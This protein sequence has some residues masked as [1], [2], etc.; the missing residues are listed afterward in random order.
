M[1]SKNTVQVLIDGKVYTLG[2]IEEAQYLQRVAGYINEKTSQLKRQEGFTKQSQEYQAVMIE[3]NIADDYF[4][5]KDR[6]EKLEQ[7]LEQKEKEIY[8]LKHELITAQI[9]SET[10]EKE[11]KELELQNRELTLKK[12]QL[13]SALEDA[14]LGPL[15]QG[16][17][18]QTPVYDSSLEDMLDDALAD[19]IPQMEPAK[20]NGSK[21][22]K[23]KK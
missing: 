8:D 21:N 16:Q 9:Q 12:T 15:E 6:I 4:K 2:G 19:S 5:A 22:K 14:L 23:G 1:S 7:D 20:P 11:N 3:L 10:S 18:P 13:E 17:E